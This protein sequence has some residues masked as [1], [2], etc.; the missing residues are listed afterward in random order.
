[1]TIE[2]I[3]QLSLE[4]ARGH[5]KTGPVY[6]TLQK[7]HFRRRRALDRLTVAATESYA[8]WF[9][10]SLV[11]GKAAGPPPSKAVSIPHQTDAYKHQPPGDDGIAPWD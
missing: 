8:E 6:R 2:E 10:R 1:M 11:F 3:R 5:V 4:Y 9:A 7:K